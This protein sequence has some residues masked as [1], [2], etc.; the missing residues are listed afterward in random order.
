M[1]TLV[2]GAVVLAVVADVFLTVLHIDRDGP[3]AGLV[4]RA[5]GRVMLWLARAVRRVRRS[6][7]A[8][9]GP[10]MLASAFAVWI[11]LFVVGFALLYWPHLAAFHA[12]GELAGLGFIDA[13]YFSGATAT[14]LGYGD[15]T[16]VRGAFQAL[17]I[18]QATLG[19]AIL[20][21]VVTYLIS[22]VTGVADRNAVALR[23]WHETGGTGDGTVIV[24]RS[25]AGEE[26]ADLARR[27][28]LLN[29]E[30]VT[31]HQKM[32]HFPILDLHYRSRDARYAPERMIRIAAGVA[33]AARVAGTDPKW[34]RIVPAATDLARIVSETM[35]LIADG[36]MGRETLGRLENPTRDGSDA[37]ALAGVRAQ[38]AAASPELEPTQQDDPAVMELVARTRLFLDA[39]DR[40]TGWRL[41]RPEA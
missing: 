33:V 39:A 41:D 2:G 38:L 18:A 16:P 27:L 22:V 19:F 17:A 15:V 6:L 26:P 31:V 4:F 21:G 37:D 35:R 12:E 13:V 3:I 14:V 23:L 9:A 28:Q 7:M 11:T 30:L 1:I 8:L 32:S 29:G 5:V 20:T 25:L 36:R 24:A 40:I 10:I 34:G